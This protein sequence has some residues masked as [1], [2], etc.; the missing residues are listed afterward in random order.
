[1]LC[2]V[3]L[4]LV[5]AGGAAT[6]VIK[7]VADTDRSSKESL[8]RVGRT[9]DGIV[10]GQLVQ[11]DRTLASVPGI[12]SLTSDMRSGAAAS[13]MLEL[14]SF[15]SPLHRDLLVVR[16]DGVVWASARPGSR[17]GAFA[18][19]TLG[20]GVA[21]GAA[22]LH[23]PLKNPLTGEWSMYLA[24]RIVLPELPEAFAVAEVPLA[25]ITGPLAN[26]AAVP[27]VRFELRDGAGQLAASY[28]HD[29][30]RIGAFGGKEG[31][32]WE[33]EGN[34]LYDGY[35]LFAIINP[36]LVLREAILENRHII[37]G[38]V[39]AEAFLV[40]FAFGVIIALRREAQL[41]GLL[42]DAIEA[43]SDGFVM[44]DP[45]D[46][47]V[48]CNQNYKDLYS[49]SAAFLVPG[50]TFEEVM[51]KGAEVGQYPQAGDDIEAFVEHMVSWRKSSKGSFERLL[52]DGRWVLATERRT[53]TGGSVGMRKDITELKRQQDLVLRYKAELHDLAVSFERSVKASAARVK[54]AAEAADDESK[55]MSSA[56]SEAVHQAKVVRG[57]AE[58]TSST[59]EVV[60]GS[61]EQLSASVKGVAQRARRAAHMADFAS[62]RSRVA[63]QVMTALDHSASQVSA[64]VDMIGELAGQ[65]NLLALNAAIE[66][67]RAGEAGRGFAV[68][69]NEVKALAAQ[70]SRSTE[71]IAKQVQ[72]IQ[73]ASAQATDSIA[74]MNTII[75]DMKAEAE[76]VE[77]AVSEQD[78]SAASITS[79]IRAAATTTSD[80]SGA[81]AMIAGRSEL[82]NASVDEMN[83]TIRR[84]LNE[85]NGL[86]TETDQFM[87]KLTAA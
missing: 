86:V 60:A 5:I 38:A 13:R 77:L 62:E 39:A 44:W 79:S 45:R 46:R 12:L 6:V 27:G 63:T 84:L 4:M 64:V 55:V 37:L 18:L 61:A 80:V 35:R 76:Q 22:H 40:L 72:A 75:I 11:V 10:N 31:S 68:V 20:T 17:R 34:A 49:A 78:H 19:K 53:V 36:D 87:R 70:T 2:T 83:A 33:W 3:V 43:M 58:G 1:M 24:R 73:T 71:A 16:P 50:A 15:Q 57:S 56:A 21:P 8:D 81:V 48:I 59:V 65:T 85:A 32:D 52:P 41:S 28:P 25:M 9:A 82:I 67:A 51:R 23:G 42:T 26:L 30:T 69:A 54:K 66:S 7:T 47:M 14:L 29:E 74:A